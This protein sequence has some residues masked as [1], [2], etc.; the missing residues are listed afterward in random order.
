MR[1]LPDT[2]A[3]I[4]ERQA[5]RPSP[6]AP[7]GPFPIDRQKQVG[8][9]LMAALGFDFD[10]GR[11][12]ASAHPFCGGTP[13]DVRIT[14]RYRE[15]DFGRALMGV[16]H[17][18]GHALYERGLPAN[19]RRQPVGRARSMSIHESQSLLI[20]MQACRSREFLEFLAPILR[21]T[22]GGRGAAW[23]PENLYRWNT[24][25]ER[26][27]IRVDA[28]E[29]T[30][31]AHVILRYR[32]EKA[33]IAGDLT[34]D[35]LPGAWRDGMRALVGIV[36]LDDRDGVLQ[37]IHWYQGL[38]G[39]FSTYTLGA[40]TA[41]QLFQSA[42]AG[43]KVILPAIATGDFRPLLGWLRHHVHARASSV[44]AAR[45]VADAT[46]NVL[47]VTIFERHLA[48]RYLRDT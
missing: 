6:L 47:D 38:F 28:D 18:T 39:Y 22:F 24:R 32:L 48:T 2:I 37:D 5:S 35:E 10:H 30:Y 16:L 40:M 44:P 42:T 46:G 1:F 3:A 15:D 43:Q 17:E 11:L 13:D 12:D 25:V 41:A 27:L 19:W 34:L 20:E 33:L 23:E 31:P 45:I 29:A 4:I 36:P 14:T 9:K 7:E 26:S 21:D 8:L